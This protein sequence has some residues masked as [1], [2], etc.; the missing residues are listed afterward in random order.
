V[1]INV[2]ITGPLPRVGLWGPYSAEFPVDVEN[3]TDNS[4]E[5]ARNTALCSFL[6]ALN[7]ARVTSSEPQGLK[8]ATDFAAG[9]RWSRKAYTADDVRVVG[10]F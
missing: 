6:S 7:T 8:K 5:T 3:K 1:R 2:T 10:A 4:F 9:F